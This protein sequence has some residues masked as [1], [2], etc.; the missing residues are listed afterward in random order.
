VQIYLN[1]MMIQ[2]DSLLSKPWPQILRVM[3]ALSMLHDIGGRRSNP[4]LHKLSADKKAGLKVRS[5]PCAQTVFANTICCSR[6]SFMSF[7]NRQFSAKG[8]NLPGQ[9]RRDYYDLLTTCYSQLATAV[10]IDKTVLQ[11]NGRYI[12]AI[13]RR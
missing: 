12:F 2:F 9:S 8:L 3:T 11:A 1:S 4:L 13:F 6:D 7:A 5:L 10:V